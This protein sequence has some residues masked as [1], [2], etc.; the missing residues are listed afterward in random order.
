MG[1]SYN[2]FYREEV[3]KHLEFIEKKYWNL[4]K[5]K[6]DEQLKHEPSVITKNRKPL[7]NPQIENRWEIRF[8]PDNNFRVFYEIFEES[9]KVE[10]VAIGIKKK[11]KLYIAGKEIK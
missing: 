3:L 9:K 1:D 10:V 4:I 7:V 6:I 8:G 11:E 2:I 5:E